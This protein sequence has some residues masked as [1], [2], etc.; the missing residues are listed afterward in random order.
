MRRLFAVKRNLTLKLA[1]QL[2]LMGLLFGVSAQV[3]AAACC[4]GGLPVPA[5]V[6]GDERANVSTTLSYSTVG[7]DVN[8]D[9]IWQHRQISE[10]AQTLRLDSARILSDRT[11]L[12]ASLPIIRRSHADDSAAGIGDVA[13]NG[14]Y[15]FLPE[16]EYSAW[17]PR[18]LGYLQLTLPTGRSIYEA[19]RVDQIDSRGRGFWALGTGV[20]LTKIRGAYDGI[21]L[22]DVHRS[23]SKEAKGTTAGDLQLTP[24]WGGGL[25]FG[26]GRTYKDL[27]L[28]ASL[29]WIYEDGTKVS[30][31]VNSD[32]VLSRYAVAA[33]SLIYTPSR[34]W[35][36]SLSYSDQ[37]LF[38]SP[39]NT[40]L[41]QAVQ[42]SY[43]HRWPR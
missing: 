3:R 38:G 13:V 25:T 29:A 8:A 39:A 22:V 17:K 23:F 1:I 34:D 5:L 6:L 26:A 27:R 28:G 40:P 37:T 15:E 21:L 10:Q 9:G 43:Q 14:G 12:G 41:A 2:A 33:A 24:G 18:G 30:G 11:Q 7:T 31:A 20:A 4:G 32:G 16:W 42:V 35:S 19:S 36:A